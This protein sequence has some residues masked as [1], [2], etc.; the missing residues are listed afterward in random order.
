[1]NYKRKL[2]KLN[3]KYI[4]FF[5][6][7]AIIAGIIYFSDFSQFVDSIQNADL[8]LLVPAFILGLAVFPVWSYVWY[9]IFH[10]M[11]IGTSYTTALEVFMSGFFMNSVT[12]LGQFGGEPVMA[13]IVKDSQDVEYKKAISSVFSAD[14]I[15]TVPVLT[16]GIGGA[17]YAFFFRSVR[18]MMLQGLYIALIVVA[19]GGPLMY[20]LWFESDKL[21]DVLR[22]ILD[23]LKVFGLDQVRIDSLMENVDDTLASFQ[24]IGEDPAYLFKTGLVAHFGFVIQVFC[25]YFV[26]W[27]LGHQPD[28]T[29]LYFIIAFSGLANFSPTPGGSG[30]FEAAMAGLVSLFLPVSFATGISAA[31]IYRMTTYWPGLIIGYFTLNRVNGGK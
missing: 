11:G 9:R 30:T 5:I 2:A 31:I 3:N 29:P 1:M 23:K 20:L 4:W 17:I 26:L 12:P 8:M 19:I 25:L 15:N 21:K 18:Q 10:K 13:Y 6:S 24:I 27:S 16:F 14:V 7:T 22:V 28:I